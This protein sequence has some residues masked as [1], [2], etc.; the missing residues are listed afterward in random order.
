MFIKAELFDKTQYV[1]TKYYD[2]V[3]HYYSKINGDV[4][5]EKLKKAIYLVVNKVDILHS[6]FIPG[7]IHAFWIKRKINYNKLIDYIEVNGSNTII[8]S[9]LSQKI[10]C[11]SRHQ[12]KC[13]LVKE[14]T[15]YYFLMIVNHMCVDGQDFKY[16]IK[17]IVETYN[18]LVLN[19]SENISIKDGSR[20]IKQ[21][22][23]NI[24]QNIKS[25]LKEY[26][27]VSI[28][29]KEKKLRYFPRHG[30]KTSLILRKSISSDD[31]NL[32]KEK[33]KEYDV[34]I[35]DIYLS[36]YFISLNSFISNDKDKQ[37]NI[38]SMVDLR[39]YL[40]NNDSLGLTNLVTYMP[41]QI[42][43]EDN[44]N[45]I[46]VVDK[47]SKASKDIKNSSSFGLES[48]SLLS[49]AYKIFAFPLAKIAIKIGY[50][51]PRFSLSNM[52][53]LNQ[54]EYSF[55]N[56]KTVDAYVTGTIKKLPYQQISTTTFNN[57]PSFC[58]ANICNNKNHELI[59]SILDK[60]INE[61]I[62]FAR[63][64]KN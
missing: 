39:R 20:S 10:S 57:E 34:T 56:T 14:D 8:E 62:K 4:E 22:Y 7:I 19:N 11:L 29:K 61:L 44:D 41:I 58:M 26:H 46:S 51:N 25:N 17:K 53:I 13:L 24:N 12:F 28:V 36:A 52:G 31:F 47:V 42:D 1:F 35:N 50:S 45:F 48:L 21:I 33:A 23:D 2:R 15:T 55:I 60:F 32:L 43:I 9:F 59:S 64:K 3:I 5:L 38:T 16:L 18:N 6:S 63:G 30:K 49:L 27:N 54:E 40:K 37:I